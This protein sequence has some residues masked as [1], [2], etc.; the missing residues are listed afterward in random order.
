MLK[1]IILL[2]ILCTATVCHADLEISRWNVCQGEEKVIEFLSN[3]ELFCGQRLYA[4]AVADRPNEIFV[5]SLDSDDIDGFRTGQIQGYR[6]PKVY[7]LNVRTNTAYTMAVDRFLELDI[8]FEDLPVG[9]HENYAE[10]A[11]GADPEGHGFKLVAPIRKMGKE[12]VTTLSSARKT[13]EKTTFG[14]P[15]IIPF[16][17]RSGWFQKEESHSGIFFLEIFDKDHP[18]KPVVQLQKI[19]KN[20]WLLPSVFEMAAWAQGT[21]EPILVVVDDETP[22]KHKEARIL[23][24]RP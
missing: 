17:G 22:T 2:S 7:V 11:F 8:L 3:E 21:E 15:S 18:S 16:F 4:Y 23:L 9:R 20:K 10:L 14:L 5:T 13:T 6:S 19:F 24:I 12:Y 1:K